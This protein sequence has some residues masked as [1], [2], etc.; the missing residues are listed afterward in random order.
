MDEG[1]N[2][3]QALNF[4]L[5]QSHR[6]PRNP[7]GGSLFAPDLTI[8]VCEKNKDSLKFQALERL[9]KGMDERL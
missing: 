4:G 6:Q 9:V 1:S 3:R 7:L 8:A 2:R 5:R